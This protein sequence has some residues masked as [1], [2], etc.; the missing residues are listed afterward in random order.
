MK[1]EFEVDD[2]KTFIDA[3]NN[4]LISY[5]RNIKA[6]RLGLLDGVPISLLSLKDLDSK[7]LDAR[8]DALYSVYPRLL[9]IEG[10]LA[11]SDD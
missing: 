8:L 1:I 6:L 7:I 9:Q 5:E 4:A 10:E 2:L 3:Y 11:R